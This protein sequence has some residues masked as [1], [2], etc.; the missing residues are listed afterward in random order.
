VSM[1]LLAEMLTRTYYE[2]QDK[3]IYVIR[4]QLD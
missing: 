2:A 3:P 1:K 4:E